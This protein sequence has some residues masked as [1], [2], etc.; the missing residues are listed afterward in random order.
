[1]DERRNDDERRPRGVCGRRGE[2]TTRGA[3]ILQGALATAAAV[4][5]GAVR[6]YVESAFA[7]SDPSITGLRIEGGPGETKDLEI[8][9]FALTLELLEAEYYDRALDELTLTPAVAEL[10]ESIRDNEREH[11]ELLQTAIEV[12]G[13]NP[14]RAPS[15]NFMFSEEAA[16]LELA[17]TLEETGVG[18]YNGAA[19][20]LTSIQVQQVAGGIVQ[21]EGRHAGAI[22]FQ[23]GAT[24]A[25]SFD[26]ALDTN[27]V[28]SRIAGFLGE[29]QE[30]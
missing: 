12:L 15:F 23:R 10:A 7:Q 17:Q 14:G 16:F 19:P 9:D 21:I 6:P 18:A 3:F 24:I 2:G 1:M 22:K 26:E 4:G 25:P 11:A 28:I 13:G 29:R 8:L 30:L 27:Q 5:V 20:L